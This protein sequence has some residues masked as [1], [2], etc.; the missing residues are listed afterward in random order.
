MRIQFRIDRLN[1]DQ[2][3]KYLDSLNKS[4]A[5][6]IQKGVKTFVKN[7]FNFSQ[8]EKEKAFSYYKDFFYS[9]IHKF[10]EIAYHKD[11]LDK[12]DNEVSQ[13]H[14]VNL[15]ELLELLN[16]PKKLKKDPQAQELTD[17]MYYNGMKFEMTEGTIYITSQ[18]DFLFD[19]FKSY[20]SEAFQEYLAITKKE[21][22]ETCVDDA[23]ILIS[24]DNLGNRIITWE[25]FMEKYSK[26]EYFDDIRNRHDWYLKLFLNGLNNSPLFSYH[27]YFLDPNIKKA[28]EN[29]IQKN[30]EKESG[31][32]V[33]NFYELLKSEG[34]KKSPKVNQ[35]YKNNHVEW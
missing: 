13:D 17:L 21:D 22:A 30:G 9:V 1:L 14:G 34:F 29:F 23:C 6:S 19:N 27:D 33:K 3:Q 15:N 28:Y 11:I 16:N 10:G 32:L 8:E 12:L 2:Y 7:Q 25:N 24:F 35:F 18:P 31:K 4:D 20:L 26:F 5:N